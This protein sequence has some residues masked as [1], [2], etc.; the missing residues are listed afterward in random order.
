MAR[1]P[2]W[3]PAVLALAGCAATTG[4]R[5]YGP[6]VFAVSEM[7]APVLGGAAEAQRVAVGEAS[8][9]CAQSGR[10]FA[11]I[12]MTPGGYPGSP[13]GPVDFTAVFACR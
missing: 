5:P 13:Y 11:P 2:W 7:R 10:T 8:A 4:V 6:G 9:F 1:E 12:S 3:V